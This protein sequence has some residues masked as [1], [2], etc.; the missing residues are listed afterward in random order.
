MEW[1]VVPIKES[2]AIDFLRENHAD[3]EVIF[4]RP[5]DEWIAVYVGDS[6]A[7]VTGINHKKNFMSVDCTYVAKQYRGQ[8]ILKAFY[9]KIMSDF[10]DSDFVIYCRPI[11]AHVVKKYYGF[12]VTQKWSNGTEKC[13]LRR[14]KCLKK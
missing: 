13:I 8:G 7:G 12:I 5:C 3:R 14:K 11:A 10:P 4:I 9:A 1:D 2:D 6:L